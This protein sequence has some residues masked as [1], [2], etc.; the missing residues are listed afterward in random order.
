M[1]FVDIF[2]PYLYSIII[3][4]EYDEFHNFLS[5]L[6]DPSRLEVYFYENQDILNFYNL[7]VEDAVIQTSEF[8]VELYEHLENNMNNL[9]KVFEPLKVIGEKLVLHKMK[10][11]VSWIRL[12]AIKIE[13]EYYVITGG[14]IKQS[15]KMNDHPETQLQLRKMEIVRDFLMSQG[16]SDI[17]G[18]FELINE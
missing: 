18:F 17:D 4:N 8:A 1:R 10:L 7:S 16:I 12:Y 11:K 14:A 9:D 13:S 3:D 6:T 5:F 2:A 15:Q